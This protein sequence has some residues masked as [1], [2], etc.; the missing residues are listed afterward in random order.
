M[1]IDDRLRLQFE[2]QEFLF[3]EANL[4]DEQRYTD[5]L[6]LLTEDVSYWAPAVEST[7]DRSRT[8]N[9]VGNAGETSYFEDDRATLAM[10]IARLGFPGAWAEVPPSRTR[11]FITNVLVSDSSGDEMTVTSNFFLFRSR[12]ESEEDQYYGSRQDLL[13]RRDGSLKLA[14]RKIVLAQAV[15]TSR[16]ITTFF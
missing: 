7:D 1:N 12:L 16:S 8:A 10:R 3:Y 2:A 9:R 14:K 4:L 5:W 13:R 11:H 6:S 15:L